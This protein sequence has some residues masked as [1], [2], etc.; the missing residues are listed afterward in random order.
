LRAPFQKKTGELVERTSWTPQGGVVSPVLANLFLHYT[1]DTWMARNHPNNPW[2]RYADD[3]VIH[4]H[5]REEA[6]RLLVQLKQRFQEC[7]LELHPVKTRIIYCKDDDRT[8]T[9]S[10]IKFNFLGYTFRPRRSKNRH[11]K[12]FINFTPAVRNKQAKP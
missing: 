3:A 9:Y 2:A 11:D 7:K 6:E 12:Y 1:F 5:T 4:S 10:E 8:G